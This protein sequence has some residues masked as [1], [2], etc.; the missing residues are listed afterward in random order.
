[1]NVLQTG[2]K[3]FTVNF[4]GVKGGSYNLKETSPMVKV[5]ASTDGSYGFEQAVLLVP[6]S[7]LEEAF[8]DTGSVAYK[9]IMELKTKIQSGIANHFI[10]L[11]SEIIKTI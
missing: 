1:M 4:A 8:N 3:E 7:L 11:P 9:N 2:T 5:A 6:A 10:S